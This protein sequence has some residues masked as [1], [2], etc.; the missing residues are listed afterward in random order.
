MRGAIELVLF[1]LDGT[2]VETAPEICDAVNDTLLALDL[3]PASLAQVTDWIGH[4]TGVLLEQAL[5]SA[6][7]QPL[8]GLRETSL[9]RAAQPRFAQDYERR[10]GTT[11]RPYPGARELLRALG[12]IGIRRA[13]VTNKEQRF[14]TPVLRRHALRPL[15]DRVVCGDSLPTRKPDP[16]GVL[17]C[18]RAFGVPR[19]RAVFVGDSSID[20]ATARN[21]GVPVWALTHGYNMGEPIASARPDLLMDRL[22]AVLDAAIA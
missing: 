20:V 14:T 5:A 6:S 9:W 8:A 15:L 4:G 21:A 3:P 13:L 2:L 19:E 18:L 1:D 11:S 10:C 22:D 17:D 12:E 16:A 7:G